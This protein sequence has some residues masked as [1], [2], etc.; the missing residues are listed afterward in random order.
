MKLPEFVSRRVSSALQTTG[1]IRRMGR[2]HY[3]TAEQA[4]LIFALRSRRHETDLLGF[5]VSYLGNEPFRWALRE[6]FIQGDYL[7]DAGTDF[8]VILD[9]GANI[10]L[11]ML[12]FK[13]LYPKA[14]ISCFEADPTTSSILQK[15]IDQNDLQDVSVHNLMLSNDDG[16][17]SFYVSADVDGSLRM[18]GNPGRISKHREIRVKAGRLSDYIDGTIDLLKLDV[19]GAEF[20]VMNDLKSTG[21]ISQIRRMVIEYHHKIDGKASCL[22]KFLALLEEEGFEYQISAHCYPITKQNLF[23]DI[24]IG[25]YRPLPN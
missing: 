1:D 22:A 24:L 18:S 3:S 23:Q 12:Y 8:P 9:C 17:Q 13:H 10:G 25:A 7:F 14:R 2:L 21:K 11:A 4:S 19:E 5:H 20:D 16:E 15:N 6:V